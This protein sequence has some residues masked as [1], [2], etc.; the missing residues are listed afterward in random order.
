YLATLPEG[1]NR[2]D[3]LELVEREY[4]PVL[5]SQLGRTVNNALTFRL[6]DEV[7]VCYDLHRMQ[8]ASAWQGG[9][10]DLSETHHYR[11]RGE[12]MPQIDGQPLP[13][14]STWQWAMHGTFDSLPDAK[15]PRG[16]LRTELLNYHG[17]YLHGD[18]A[19]LSYAIEGRDIL[20]SVDASKRNGRVVLTHT[21]H[22]GA[23]SNEMQLAT[24]QLRPTGGPKGI[25]RRGT[26]T[27]NASSW[28]VFGPATSDSLAVVTGVPIDRDVPMPNANEALHVVRG[29]EAARLDL[30]TPRRT[31]LVRFRSDEGGTL[32][33]SAPETGIWKA[34]G[35]TLFIRN[36]RLVFDIGWV[37]AMQGRTDVADK[38]WHVAALVVDEAATRLYVDGRLEAQREDFRRDAE[39]GFVLKVGATAANFGGDLRGEIAWVKILDRALPPDEIATLA[40]TD[41]AP[42]ESGEFTWSPPPIPTADA[43]VVGQ[44]TDWKTACAVN[45]QGDVRGVSWT[46]DDA[47]RVILHVPASDTA[48]RLRIVRTVVSNADDLAI[49]AREAAELAQ[50]PTI[51]LTTLLHGGPPR[52]PEVI[53]TPGKLGESING[54]ALDSLPVPFENPWNAWLRTSA[55]DFLPD[56]RAVM[57]THG[58]DVYLVSGIDAELSNVRWKRFVAGLFEPFGVRVVDGIIYV[59]CRDGIKRLHDYDH[60]DEADFIEAFW[61]DDDVSCEFHAFNFDLQTDRSGNFY[62]AKAGQYT[63]H[64]RPGTIMRV[65]PQGGSA[66]VV[67]WGLR[68]PNGMGRLP[69]DRFTVSD[70]QGPWMPAGK[71]SLITPDTFLG[72]MPINEEQTKWLKQRHGGQLPESFEEPIVWTPQELDNSCGGQVWADDDRFGPLSGRLIHSSFGKGWL[73]TMS[74]Q[75]V[76]GKLQGS[77]IALPHQWDAGVM[78]L[79]INPADGQL[80]GTGLSGWQG[81]TGGLD[82]CLQRLRYTGQPVR[83]IRDVRVTSGGIE[84]TFSFPVGSESAL[85]PAS[86]SAEMWNYLWS[87]RYGSDQFSV[88]EPGKQGHDELTITAVK[89]IDSERVLLEMPDLAVCD[90]LQLRML[91]DDGEQQ[92][93]AEEVFLTIH[94]IPAP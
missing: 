44:Q 21:L 16:P 71:V 58:G 4:G 43:T 57:T 61:T 74:L 47:G 62:F 68:T 6:P 77:I 90:Q 86:Y 13:A 81:P 26:A 25:W 12:R 50:A 72:N 78:R 23:G 11:Q 79:R 2:G 45:V 38:Q 55:I 18:R 27:K 82:G 28:E 24:G 36:R 70:N 30:G 73:Y 35:K 39:P 46:S 22:V 76:T 92:P 37:G 17:H 53:E 64:H 33:S 56:G 54:Y 34:N 48:R 93:Y 32:V 41:S 65:P 40:A 1:N 84:L 51:D 88:R 59:T 52:W 20:E 19:I 67:A 87:R 91:F 80:Y 75:E 94:G 49:F 85:D 15:P 29:E 5:G 8:I 7:S 69:D 66:E 10:L 83:F 63:D 14:L 42:A 60:N 3:Q 9:F 31:L 89:S